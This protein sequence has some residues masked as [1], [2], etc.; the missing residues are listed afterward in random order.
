[1]KSI[2]LAV[3]GVAIAVALPTLVAAQPVA[4]PYISLGAGVGLLQDQTVSAAPSIDEPSRSAIFD[5]GFAG[6]I[7]LG[8]GFGNGMRVEIEGDFQDNRLRRFEFP[9][10]EVRRAGGSELQYGGMVNALYDFDL[11]LPVYP[12]I[13][14]GVGGQ[15]VEF[16]GF[17]SSSPSAVLPIHPGSPSVADFAYQG[18]AGLSVPLPWVRGLSF[19]AEYRM[20]GLLSPLPAINWTSYSAANGHRIGTAQEQFGNDFNHEILLGVRYA[21]G[22]PAP[23]PPPTPAPVAAPAAAP[24]RSYLVFFDWDKADLTDRARSIVKEAADNAARV[25]VTRIEVNGYTDTSGSPRYNQ[26]L[27]VRRAQ[28]VAGELVRDGVPRGAI[29]IQGFGETHLL[30]ATGPGVREPQNRRVEIILR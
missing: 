11:G 25:Q 13:G 18:I 7:S 28:A 26:D 2:R 24:A 14:A 29:T 6:Q 22:A 5:P 20:L 17:N 23:V 21:F 16:D 15:I 4:G 10:G 8:W 12:Y 9:A 19:T 1:M 3:A 27:S 30:V